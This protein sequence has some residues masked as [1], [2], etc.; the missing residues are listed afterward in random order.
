MKYVCNK[1]AVAFLKDISIKPGEA[2][3][4][5]IIFFKVTLPDAGTVR[6]YCLPRTHF[7]MDLGADHSKSHKNCCRSYTKNNYEIRSQLCTCH[8]SWAVVACAKLWAD[9]F[10]RIEIIPNL[11]LKRFWLW[12]HK[13]F[14]KWAHRQWNIEFYNIYFTSTKI[15]KY[16]NV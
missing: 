4:V 8:N 1:D 7:T 11:I 5:S 14:V 2:D 9:C 16:I 12:A 13:L 15:W 3:A 10:I 6:L